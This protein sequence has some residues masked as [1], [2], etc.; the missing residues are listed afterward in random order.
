MKCKVILLNIALLSVMLF[1]FTVSVSAESVHNESVYKNYDIEL[2]DEVKNVLESLGLEDFSAEEISNISISDTI[3]SIIDVFKGS[4]QKPFTCMCSLLGIILLCSV[5]CSFL[6]TGQSLS[7]YFDSLVTLFVAFASFSYAVECISSA[8][9]AIHSAGV[10]MKSLIPATAALVAFSG[11]PA[12][13][14]SYNAVAM[15]CAEIISAV[16]RDFLT[17]VLC[18]FS[19]VSVCMAI[20]SAFNSDAFLNAAKKLVSILL[21][22]AG[23]V[24]TGVIALKDLL[25]VGIDKVAV[26]GVKFI[27]GSS[28]PVVGSALSEGLSSVIA[29]VALMKNTYGAIGIIV[30]ITVTLPAI[31]ELIL[32]LITFSVTGYAAQALGLNGVSKAVTSL[33]YVMSLMLSILLFSIYILIV[34]A[35]LVILLGNK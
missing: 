34:T 9:A 21:G 33:R 14:V 26:K 23:T 4:L 25:A 28:V 24:F 6:N 11:T 35:A 20:N 13:A 27:L 3:N 5:S 18:V 8:V 29:S 16:C 32:W 22:L 17:P 12:M 10:L 19:A 15:Y 30:I 1:C 2:S 7:V 31:C